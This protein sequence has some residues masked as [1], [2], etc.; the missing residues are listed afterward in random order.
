MQENHVSSLIFP[1]LESSSD[2]IGS[3]RLR[4]E[5]FEQIL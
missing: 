3:T 5:V 1:S 4:Q 2:I